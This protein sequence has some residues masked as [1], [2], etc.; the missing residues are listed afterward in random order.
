MDAPSWFARVERAA[1]G[2]ALAAVIGLL[3]LA[4]GTALDV[5][6]RYRFATAIPGFVDIASLAGAVL[7]AAC[8]PYVLVVRANISVDVLGRRLGGSFKT[9]L[10]RFAA[11]VTAAFFALMAWQYVRFAMDMHE[12]AQVIP[13]LRWS[14]WPWWAAVALFIVLAAVAATISAWQRQPEEQDHE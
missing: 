14:V 9:G 1:A 12:T 7:L 5:L 4:L 11:L 3:L 8:F 10:D 2:L 13:V 6:L